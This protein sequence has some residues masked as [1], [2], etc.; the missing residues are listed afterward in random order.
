MKETLNHVF[1]TEKREIRVPLVPPFVFKVLYLKALKS[2]CCSY[3]NLC[4]SL[5]KSLRSFSSHK[6][7]AFKEEKISI[8]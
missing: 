1:E 8:P 4:E 5:V 3:C 7:R 2:L 6:L